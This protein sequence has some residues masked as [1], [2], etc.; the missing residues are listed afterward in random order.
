MVVTENDLAPFGAFPPTG[1]QAGLMAAGR[2]LQPNWFGRRMAS[3]IRSSLKRLGNGPV[4]AEVIG[5]KMRLYPCDNAGEKRLLATPQF[6]NPVEMELLSR[7]VTPGFVFIDVGANVG[8]YTVFVGR[9]AGATGRVIA[10]E[11]HPAPRARLMANLKLNELS[12]VTVAPVA[13]SNRDGEIVLYADGHNLGSTSIHADWSPYK[14]GGAIRAPMKTLQGLLAEHGVTRID[15]I[16]IDIEGAED[17][18]LAP[19]LEHAD[20]ASLPRLVIIEDNRNK[21]RIDLV[22]LLQSKK[23]RAKFER[24]GNMIFT[25]G[26]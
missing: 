18:A 7:Y 11:P 3:F 22:A 21:W 5:Q 12:N 8:A 14:G 6:F 24:G 2:R 26:E 15:G 9:R 19:F 17:D 1:L 16:K 10:I 23:Y 4:D 13:I 25:R 20:D